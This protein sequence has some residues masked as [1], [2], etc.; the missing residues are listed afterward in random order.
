MCA[1]PDGSTISLEPSTSS[2]PWSTQAP[3][4]VVTHS[5][6]PTKA[7]DADTL[8]YYEVWGYTF[9]GHGSVARD[10]VNGFCKNISSHLVYQEPNNNDATNG[11]IMTLVGCTG[12]EDGCSGGGD[13]LGD[14]LGAWINI[15]MRA[16]PSCLLNVDEQWCLS[17][18]RRCLENNECPSKQPPYSYG[19]RNE[20]SCAAFWMLAGART[21]P[22]DP[23]LD[24]LTNS[25]FPPAT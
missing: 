1:V 2:C 4:A 18:L 8:Q 21:F 24:E 5:I 6:C 12:G 15:Y 3:S 19:G 23:P 16:K 7:A 13:T 25:D 11:L 22:D 9:N 10:A 14:Y 20:D 17:M